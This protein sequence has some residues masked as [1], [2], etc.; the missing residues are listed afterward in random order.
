VLVAHRAVELRVAEGED[1][2]V[3]RHRPVAVED[4]LGVVLLAG[5]N[6]VLPGYDAVMVWDGAIVSEAVQVACAPTMAAAA[7]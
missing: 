1:A 7:Q 3:A 2:P 6:E 5:R 4:R